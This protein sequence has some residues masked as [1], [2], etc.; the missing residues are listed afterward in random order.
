MTNEVFANL[1]RAAQE[2]YLIQKEI[3][4]GKYGQP[5]HV[6][7]TT[8]ALAEQR[9]VSVVTAHNILTGL[10]AAGYLELRGKKYHLAHSQ[11]ME[12][13]NN[14]TKI[15][16][17][18]VPH[19][20]NEF[21]SSL[22]DAVILS[23][24]QKGYEVLVVATA[25]SPIEEKKV[26]QLLLNLPVAG[27]VNCVSTPQENK[28]LYRNC[29]IPC[30]LLG[31][32]LDGCKRSSVQVNSFAVSQKVARHLLEGGYREFLYIGTKNRLLENDIRF[33]GFQM[34]LKQHG[35]ALDDQHTLQVST[36]PQM[37]DVQLTHILEDYTQPIGVFCYHDLIAAQVYRACKKL[38]RRIPEDVG[39]V[40][41]DDLSVATSLSPPLTTVQYRIA[42][43]ADMTMKLLLDSIQFSNTSYDNYYV[44]P[45]LV[46]RESSSLSVS[47][48]NR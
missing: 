39:V 36:E 31:H 20:N 14:L 38:G 15:I 24:R 11:L 23:A 32:S 45:N 28:S 8:R 21:F 5:G 9:Q 29:P 25:Y 10:C 33:T 7:M 48:R 6:F 44:E 42:S 22:T 40:G 27:I 34:E 12:D 2:Q 1:S 3:L 19:L 16:G 13:H 47:K 43:M 17:M 30:V 35:Y 46:I 41:F 26:F 4:Q 37:D 18:V